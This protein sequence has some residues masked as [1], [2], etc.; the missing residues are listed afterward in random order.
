M[1]SNLQDF[2]QRYGTVLIMS[3]LY[4]K[5]KNEASSQS[6]FLHNLLT[7]VQKKNP[8]INKYPILASIAK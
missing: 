5:Q 1:F 8:L 2:H 7:K 3:T 6:G 4:S